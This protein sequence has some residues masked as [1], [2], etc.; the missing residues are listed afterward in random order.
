MVEV[1]AIGTSV[2]S[3]D[4]LDPASAYLRVVGGAS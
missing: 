1:T 2:L 3:V 4:P